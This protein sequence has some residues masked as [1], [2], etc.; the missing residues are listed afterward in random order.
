MLNKR[1]KN[2]IYYCCSKHDEKKIAIIYCKSHNLFLC[3]YCWKIHQYKDSLFGEKENIFYNMD[4]AKENIDNEETPSGEE[5][6][7]INFKTNLSK[8]FTIN[9]NNKTPLN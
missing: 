6:I 4:I 5:V 1:T 2:A 7:F 9:I 8:V 3:N